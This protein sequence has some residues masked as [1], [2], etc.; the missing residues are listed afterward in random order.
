MEITLKRPEI[1]TLR[2]N[3]GSDVVEIPLGASLTLEEYANLNTFEGTIKFYN[4]YIPESVAKNLTFNEYNQITKAWV[5]AT[6]KQS[7][8]KSGES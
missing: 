4:K 1:E 5:E 7:R 3:I 6:Q 8:V 2:V